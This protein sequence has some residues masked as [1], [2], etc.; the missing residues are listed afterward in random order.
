M[1]G[2]FIRVIL[3]GALSYQVRR[4]DGLSQ[5]FVALIANVEILS[6]REGGDYYVIRLPKGA[7][8]D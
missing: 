4:T 2:S 5:A 8:L 6:N 3:A 1:T 7:V